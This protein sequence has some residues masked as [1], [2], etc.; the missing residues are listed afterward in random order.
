KPKKVTQKLGLKRFDQEGRILQI[1]YSDFILI[2]LYFPHGGRQKENLNYKLECYNYL[3]NLL[4]KKGGK[5]IIL[6]GDFNIAH[7]EID[8]ARP[9]SN[10]N[11]IMF[12]LKEKQQL[13]KLIKLGFSDTFRNFNEN[14]INNYTWWPYSFNARERNL[15]WRIDYIFTSKKVTSRLKNAFILNKVKGSDHCPV[16]IKWNRR[17]YQ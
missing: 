8:L 2:N 6:I 16:G 12:T 17:P 3:F 9:K 1:E 10:Q 11:N 5:N 14:K 15:G 4:K 7:T 13:D